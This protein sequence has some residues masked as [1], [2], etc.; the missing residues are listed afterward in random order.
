[1]IKN[2]IRIGKNKEKLIPTINALLKKKFIFR[3][4]DVFGTATDITIN[5]NVGGI[6][7]NQNNIMI[8]E[9][10]QYLQNHS[11]EFS[12]R[13]IE[14]VITESRLNT[15]FGFN[16]ARRLYN[17]NKVDTYL[18]PVILLALIYQSYNNQIRF[19]RLGHYNSSFSKSNG[20]TPAKKN[21][22]DEFI[23]TIN[24]K[25][26]TLANRPWKSFMLSFLESDVVI[27]DLPVIGDEYYDEVSELKIWTE[28]DENSALQMCE[29]FK[30]QKTKFILIVSERGNPLL[31]VVA[32]GINLS[33]VA[34]FYIYT[35]LDSDGSEGKD[36][37]D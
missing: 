30:R 23:R 29:F 26:M 18:K 28:D 20:F 21:Q 14:K 4:V 16:Q 33:S 12:I 34:G 2:P 8:R 22:L 24:S 17:E 11:A 31:D 37:Y 36:L 10:L 13:A 3:I 19:N 15:E 7:S 9:A 1:M 25:Y 27:M 35:N 6:I 32:R 5:A